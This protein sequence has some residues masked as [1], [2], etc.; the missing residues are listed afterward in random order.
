MLVVEREYKKMPLSLDMILHLHELITKD[1][2]DDSADAGRLRSGGDDDVHVVDMQGTIYHTG[3][4]PVFV[5]MELERLITYANGTGES[6]EFT[7]PVMKAI[8]LHFWIGY[9][10][11]FTD[12][13]GRLARLLFYWSLLRDEYW[14]FTYI[15]ISR[16]IKESPSQ[17]GMAYIYTEQDNN[18]FT[19]FLD[20]HVRKIQQA[21]NDFRDYVAKKSKEHA[22][23]RTNLINTHN[24]N[25]RQIRLLQYIHANPEE[26]ITTRS[27]QKINSIAGPTAAS[28]VK[29]LVSLGF[30]ERKRLGRNVRYYATQ[31]I[32]SLF[33]NG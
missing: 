12:G 6:R 16:V 26:F 24:L 28:D 30:L 29:Q 22:V 17:Y 11:P 1:T 19:Y 8:I 9:L 21:L 10:H 13:N 4:N 7:H 5:K 3:L 31:K 15:P 32:A 18:D 27:H 14:G 20:Y 33:K 23:L 2:L 25:D